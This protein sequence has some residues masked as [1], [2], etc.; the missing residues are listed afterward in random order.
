MT[1]TLSLPADLIASIPVFLGFYPTESLVMVALDPGDTGAGRSRIGPATRADLSDGDA[2]AGT[3]GALADVGVTDAFAFFVGEGRAGEIPDSGTVTELHRGAADRGIRLLG[4]WWVPQIISGAPYR[5][6]ADSAGGDP[7][8]TGH[9]EVERWRYGVIPDIATA[10]AMR[11]LVS[12]GGVLPELTRRE[13]LDFFARSSSV[14]SEDRVRRITENAE[15]PG[16]EVVERLNPGA[17]E[18]VPGERLDSYVS[19]LVGESRRLLESGGNPASDPGL[20]SGAAGL[21][22]H[23]RI[24]DLVL[25]YAVDT[26]DA[27]PLADLML[28]VARTF[29]GEIRCN[30]LCVYAVAL[31]ALGRTTRVWPALRSSYDENPDHRLTGLL[32]SAY[33]RGRFDLIL[34]CCR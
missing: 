7:G 25:G 30:A 22:A 23:G 21:V 14:L 13:A 28:V 33:G 15:S 32:L 27:E 20:L 4:A 6:L 34:E 3:L 11:E 16:P 19:C 29:S 1:E 26:A 2:V 5:I 17:G 8:S 18:S 24:R 12:S 10:A 9:G 31:L